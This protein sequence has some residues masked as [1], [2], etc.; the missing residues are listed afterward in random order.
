MIYINL[1]FGF[2]EFISVNV[3]IQILSLFFIFFGDF[4]YYIFSLIYYNL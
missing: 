4:F 3:N 1:V 2:F